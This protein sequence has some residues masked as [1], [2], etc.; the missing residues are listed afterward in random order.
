M[1]LKSPYALDPQ[2]VLEPPQ[3]WWQTLPWLGPGFLL[4]AS[5]VG[6]GELIAT[7]TLGAKVGF[8]ALWAIL[9]SCV[10]KVAL[11][12]QFG[13]Y[14][15]LT[16]RT[17]MDAFN[18]LGGPKAAGVRWSIWLWL[19]IQPLKI[20]QVGGIIGSLALLM[21]LVVPTL[22]V[23]SWCWIAVLSVA[24]PV[25]LNRY[26]GIERI[27]LVLLAGFTL[28]TLGS[29]IALQWTKFAIEPANILGGL[30]GQIPAGAALVLLGAFGLTGVGGDEIM[31]YTYWLL[32]KGYA[33]YTGKA[34]PSDPNWQRRARGW[35][36]VMYADAIL[37]MVAYTVVTVAFYLLGAAVL[38]RQGLTPETDELIPTLSAMYTDSL[39]PWAQGL[40]LCGA[41]IVLFSTLFSALAAWTRI[42][43]DAI[44][45]LGWIDFYNDSHRRKTIA[46]LAWLFPI[47]WA[48]VHLVYKAPVTMIILGGVATSV[49]LLLVVYAAVVFR[50]RETNESLRPGKLFDLALWVSCLSICIFALYAS[51][52][53]MKWFENAVDAIA[54]TV[55]S[56][57]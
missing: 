38:H 46:V 42:F 31:Q 1:S 55:R 12:L 49:L 16:G 39:G 13:R 18:D 6:S 21:H 4:S 9:L 10:I 5:I 24:I 27:S 17:V 48:M 36:R 28:L 54:A 56:I 22:S 35:I 11:Q 23:A 32:E 37:S 50:R 25:S 40:F 47:T 3:S 29:V 7:T 33:S 41:F 14:A 51:C 44:S 19:L 26:G 45:K 20:L 52:G 2:A 8:V 57:L 30:Q 34:N 15:I 53:K 43:A